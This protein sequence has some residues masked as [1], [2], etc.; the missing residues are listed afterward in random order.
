MQ[1]TILNLTKLAERCPNRGRKHYGNGR[2]FSFEQFLLFPHCFQKTCTADTWKPEFVWER[3]NPLSS[4]KILDLSKLKTFLDEKIN[5]IKN[6]W[7]VFEK[8]ENI[9]GKRKIADNQYFLFSIHCFL[10][11]SFSGPL[12]LGL[13]GKKLIWLVQR[14]SKL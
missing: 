10:R 11:A 12:T 8:V 4:D 7:T 2:H 9:L 14:L 5:L 3:V 6:L 1:T 13:C